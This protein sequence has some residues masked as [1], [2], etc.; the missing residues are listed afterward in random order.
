MRSDLICMAQ[1]RE[2]MQ[3]CNKSDQCDSS[4]FVSRIYIE[5]EIPSSIPLAIMN[6]LRATTDATLFLKHKTNYSR[7]GGEFSHGLE[8]SIK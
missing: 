6:S 8:T 4:Q 7:N 3:R 5:L 1:H 2:E